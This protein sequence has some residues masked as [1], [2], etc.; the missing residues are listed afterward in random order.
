MLTTL[1]YQLGLDCYNAQE[2]LIEIIT[3]IF[4]SYTLNQIM[5]TLKENFAENL[6]LVAATELWTVL[7]GLMLELELPMLKGRCR[8]QYAEEQMCSP[9]TIG[10]LDATD[11][12][13]S[14]SAQYMYQFP[15]KV[16]EMMC[17]DT[18]HDGDD[19]SGMQDWM[20]ANVVQTPYVRNASK[21]GRNDPCPCGSGKK[22]KKCCGR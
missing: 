22:Y 6:N 2:C 12:I 11:D 13:R 20:K 9:W 18:N 3:D 15:A 10:M 1:H 16:Q 19:W 5:E 4:N 8:K 7:S 14:R 17:E 21:I